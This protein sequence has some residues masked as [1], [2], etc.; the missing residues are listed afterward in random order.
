TDRYLGNGR[1][2]VQRALQ[3]ATV[4]TAS[5]TT[6]VADQSIG[7]TSYNIIG[8]AGGTN[9]ASYTVEYGIG[10]SPSTWTTI[11]TS[12]TAVANASLATWTLTGLT[13]NSPYVVRLR[14]TDTT[15]STSVDQRLAYVQRSI[16]SGWPREVG[17]FVSGDG[18]ATANIDRS[19][20]QLEVALS[21]FTY[22]NSRN[23]ADM[24][25]LNHDGTY[26]PGWPQT[27]VNEYLSA[28]TVADITGEGE[29]EIFAAGYDWGFPN[30]TVKLH[31]FS[32]T[33]TQIS[34]WP[35]TFTTSEG[36]SFQSP[37]VADLDNDGTQEIVFAS[38]ASD[39][40]GPS[41]NHIVH[42]YRFDGSIL[43]GWPKTTPLGFPSGSSSVGPQGSH[44]VLVDLDG[45]GDLEIVVGVGIQPNARVYAWH[46][47]GA[48][49]AGWPV[50][51]PDLYTPNI[52]AGDIDNDGQVEIVGTNGNGWAAAYERNGAIMTGW[53]KALAFGGPAPVLAD[54]DNDRDLEML[55][56][57]HGDNIT[58]FHH[59]GGAVTGFPANVTSIAGGGIWPTAVMGDLTGDGRPELIQVSGDEGR[60]FAFQPSGAPVAGWPRNIPQS[61][62]VSPVLGDL[63]GNNSL[64]LTVGYGTTVALMDLGVAYNAATV[65][66]P[67]AYYNAQKTGRFTLNGLVG[68]LDA[69]GAVNVLD[70]QLMANVILGSQ[71]N[72]AI[73]GR[74]DLNGD[75]QRNALDL[76][77]VVN[78]ALGI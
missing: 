27:N 7:G 13:D 22:R 29:P 30:K 18:I 42:I 55:F 76:Q 50:T 6:P 48:A 56:Y 1:I 23:S 75:G 69:S 51:L 67:S 62:G 31:A 49:V 4:P 11:R 43:S 14:V 36:H 52:V 19:D 61:S 70:V 44:P 32:R 37:A 65:Q 47:T 35:K 20:A 5:L 24:H 66:W 15:G 45:D 39:Q 26:L 40:L 17:G 28:P 41:A 54:L 58:A 21:T 16:A 46:H 78:R 8:S 68:D 53:P 33:G 2:N 60:I 57:T 38:Y 72:P 10:V 64:D 73:V 9:F 59:T 25:L 3:M 74:A 34:G 77:I 71:T 63:D 12:T